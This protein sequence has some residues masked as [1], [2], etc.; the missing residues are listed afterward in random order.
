VSLP[1]SLSAQEQAVLKAVRG[2]EF[3]SVEV[4]VHDGRIVE[5]NQKRKVRFQDPAPRTRPRE[6]RST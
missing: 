3:G 2:L 4:V 6:D 5:V 1:E